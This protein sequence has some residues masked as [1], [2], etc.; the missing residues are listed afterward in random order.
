[1]VN[2]IRGASTC[3]LTTDFGT[4]DWYVGALKGTLLRLAPG[5]SLLDLSHDIA[6]GDIAAASLVLAGAAPTFPPGTLHLA[7]VDPGVGSSRRL[8]AVHASGQIFLAPDNGLLTPFLT[9][10]VVHAVDRPDLYLDAPGETFHG[11]DRFAPIAAALFA[12]T[13]LDQLGPRIEDAAPLAAP[14][15]SRDEGRGV[16]SGHVVHVDRYGNLV[17]DVPSSWVRAQRVSAKVGGAF[18][19]R[20]ATHY[21]ELEPGV[22]ALIASSL[23]TIEV[24]LR[25][26]SAAAALA[27]RRGDA[28]T[29]ELQAPVR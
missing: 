13:P 11:R 9:G 1:M 16:I 10:G 18:V 15:P 21:A 26:H 20:L 17:T 14:P 24:A 28:I 29:I 12:G 8:L 23:G 5:I 27:V 4:A 2:T 3:T 25:D 22:P 6:P 7:V 19:G